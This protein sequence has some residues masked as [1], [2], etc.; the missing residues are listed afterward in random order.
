[1]LRAPDL[2]SCLP[3]IDVLVDEGIG[4]IELTMTTPGVLERAPEIVAAYG[5]RIRIGVGT[6]TRVGEVEVLADAGVGLLVTPVCLPDVIV[7]ARERGVAMIAGSLTPTEIWTAWSN[8]AAAVKVFP[9]GAVGPRYV[10]DIHGPFPGL[11]LV[12]S[13][14]VGLDDIAA[15]LSAG[16]VAVSIGGPLLGDALHGGSLAGLRTRAQ[17]AVAASAQGVDFAAQRGIR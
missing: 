7:A 9:A 6:V 12:P 13:G 10:A 15:W 1:M 8:G 17:R 3:V 11:P 2:D 14:G 4:A 16:A 5:D